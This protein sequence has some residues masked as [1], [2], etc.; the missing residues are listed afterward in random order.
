MAVVML[1]NAEGDVG[2]APLLPELQGWEVRWQQ[3]P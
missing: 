1:D 2:D 3:L